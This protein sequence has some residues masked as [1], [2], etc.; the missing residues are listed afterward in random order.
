MLSEVKNWYSLEDTAKR[1]SL[2]FGEHVS[3]KSVLQLCCERQ[4][5]LSVFLPPTEVIEIISYCPLANSYKYLSDSIHKYRLPPHLLHALLNVAS[6]KAHQ[7]LD[8]RCEQVSDHARSVFNKNKKEGLVES[9]FPEV[10]FYTSTQHRTE[11]SPRGV[12]PSKKTLYKRTRNILFFEDVNCLKKLEGLYQLHMSPSVHARILNDLVIE[13]DTSLPKEK[14]L[15]DW[16]ICE[17]NKREAQTGYN[18]TRPAR[19][20]KWCVLD[21]NGDL[22]SPIVFLGNWFPGSYFP[23]Y[24]L[25]ST[26]LDFNRVLPSINKMVIQTKHL[27]E[28][29]AKYVEEQQLKLTKKKEPRQKRQEQALRKLIDERGEDVLKQ[30][31]RI[32]IWN[33]LS[34]IDSRL[35]PHREKADPMVSGFFRKAKMIYIRDR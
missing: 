22:Y 20:Y 18:R 1:L 6:N 11:T 2:Y 21:D 29:E 5:K 7:P 3:I 27:I 28:F 35:F 33:L 12:F 31:G 14:A 25:G 17:N 8:H 10:D 26:T 19:D 23:N 15:W 30:L 32:G 24:F 34:D 13:S 4:L 9:I 16:N